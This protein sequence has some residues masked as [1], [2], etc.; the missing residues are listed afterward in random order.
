MGWGDRGRE[1]TSEEKASA[2]LFHK[3]MFEVCVHAERKQKHAEIITIKNIAN[4][5]VL[6]LAYC[7]LL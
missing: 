4:A 6:D 5:G 3:F 1:R 2:G 7:A